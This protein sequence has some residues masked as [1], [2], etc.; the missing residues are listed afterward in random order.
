MSRRRASPTIATTWPPS[1]HFL[2]CDGHRNDSHPRQLRP[3]L[4]SGVSARGARSGAGGWTRAGA[5]EGKWPEPV[6]RTPR[7]G[8]TASPHPA[9]YNLSAHHALLL[10]LGRLADVIGDATMFGPR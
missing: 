5:E 8:A 7:R 4:R 3:L 2:R 9:I 10:R 1:R 6:S